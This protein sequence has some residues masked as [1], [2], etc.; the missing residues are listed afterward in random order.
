[1][2]NFAVPLLDNARKASDAMRAWLALPPSTPID[3]PFADSDVAQLQ[4]VS[5][6]PDGFVLDDQTWQDLLLA[7]WLAGV[8]NEVSIAGRQELYRR[9]RTGLSD[10]ER[11]ALAH[12]LRALQDEPTRIDALKEALRT[13]READTE[14]AALLFEGKALMPP[15]W[16]GWRWL[17]PLALIGSIAAVILSPL[18]WI[19]SAAVL[20]TLIALQM[21]YHERVEAWSRSLKTVQLLLGAASRLGREAPGGMP[22]AAGYAGRLNHSL[23]RSLVA[24]FSPDG[25]AYGDWFALANVRHYFRTHALVLRER[26]FLQT[27]WMHCA[28][29]E[30]DAALARHLL[31][32]TGWCWSDTAAEGE[33]VIEDGIHPLL[34]APTGLSIGLEGQGAFISGP[35]GVGKSTFLRMLGLN[36]VLARAF[37][38]CYARSARLPTLPVYASMQNEDSL[39]G[40]QSLYMSE[41]ARAQ[42]LLAAADGPHPGVCLIDEIFRGTNHVE[43]VAASAAVL[44]TLAARSMVLVSS[45]NLV[46]ASLLEHRLAPHCIGRDDD[47]RLALAPGVLDRTN[48]IALLGVQGFGA[49]IEQKAQRVAAW[50]TGYLGRPEAGA[51][52]LACNGK[53]R[54]RDCK[55][56]PGT[57][58]SVPGSQAA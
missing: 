49:E 17:L 35:N 32:N 38:I 28:A 36:L 46:L 52:V 53:P 16:L 56:K 54:V 30:A 9:L 50:L 29:L 18:A 5:A 14:I 26:A 7:P 55:E 3:Y 34:A 12:R 42:A 47:G 11:A 44:D 19:A 41:L 33:L 37:G 24:R 40:G 6:D 45:H 10:P 4:R 2:P 58:D 43:S 1:M 39:Q 25:G 27:C 51:H 23:S 13:L 48:G 8:S 31:A 15:G 22:D 20:Y 21:R 57:H